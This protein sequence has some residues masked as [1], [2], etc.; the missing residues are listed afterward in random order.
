[1]I[2]VECDEYGGPDVLHVAERPVPKAEPGTVRV[3]VHAAA[4]NPADVKLRQG[5]FDSVAPLNFPQVLGYDI[6]GTVDE[7]GPGVTGFF[8]GERVFA[9][10]NMLQRGAYAEYVL[11]P[12]GDLVLIPENLD[13]ATAVSIPTGGLTGHQMIE[14]YAKPKA[15][16]CVLITGAT[17]S[18]GRFAMLAAKK[19]GA[20]IVAAVREN[21]AAEA[22]TLGAA[23]LLILGAGNWQGPDFKY[24]IDTVGGA[25]VAKLCRHLAPGGGIFTAA[26]TPIEGA[27]LP[28][29]PIFVIVHNEP[30]QLHALA[31]AAA[32]GALPVPVAKRLPLAQAAEA[33][34][35]VEAGGNAG[36][37]VLEF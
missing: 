18:V 6:A 5:M 21:Q 23:E 31:E 17:G 8:A 16:E 4:V 9:M 22:S 2:V 26:T 1:M 29:A 15:G 3:R 33:H 19:R 11:V 30:A 24:V 20:H 37:I 7:L 28:T 14:E 34:R 36:K 27:D 10:L 35:L 25:D 13:F 32:S 12:A